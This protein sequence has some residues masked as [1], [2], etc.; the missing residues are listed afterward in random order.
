MISLV[1]TQQLHLRLDRIVDGKC[2][3]ISGKGNDGVLHGTAQVIPD[4][5]LGASLS[6]NGST[7]SLDL[8]P[9]CIPVGNELTV[10]FWAYGGST[11][12]RNSAVIEATGAG[13]QI[14]LSIR[15]PWGDGTVSFRCGN[16]GAAADSIA[17]AAQAS[18][19]QGAWTHW[20]FTKSATNGQMMIYRNGVL[21]QT[22]TG[23]T[24]AIAASSTVK[25][26]VT[27]DGVNYYPGKLAQ[28][29][30]YS[31][32][33]S[34][35]AI[36]HDMEADQTALS[37][38]RKSY[39]I[40]FRLYNDDEQDV[41]DITDDPAGQNLHL[42]VSNASG[43]VINLVAPASTEA[44]AS[45]YH[46][47]L[48]FRPDVLSVAAQTYTSY[49]AFALQP[50]QVQTNFSQ[51]FQLFTT[52]STVT[53]TPAATSFTVSQSTTTPTPQ[54]TQQPDINSTNT[55]QA[56]AVDT[57]STLQGTLQQQ[58]WSL[59][60]HQEPDASVTIYFLST[61]AR[62]LPPGAQVA[63]TFPHVSASG[64]GGARGTRVELLYQQLTFGSDASPITG[65][66]QIYLSIVNQRGQKAIP[67]HVNFVGFNTILN[68]GNTQNTL[69][70]RITNVLR[71][72]VIA[73]NPAGSTTPSRFILSFDVQ[74]SGEVRDWALGTTSQVNAIQITP[75]DVGN[76]T[77]TTEVEGNSP[78]WIVTPQSAKT[79]L[80]ADEALQLTI[81]N[82]ISSLPSSQSS[83]YVRY[84]NIPG[85][86]D[87]QFVVTIEKS[88]LLYR[89][90]NVG[91]GALNPNTTLTISAAG[92]PPA[93]QLVSHL[94]LRRE[95]T[96]QSGD[97]ILFLELYQDDHV[98]GALTVP[99]VHPSIRFHHS[100]R[101]WQRI[102][103]R[104]DGIHFKTGDLTSDGYTGVIAGNGYFGGNAG[105]AP[106][107]LHAPLEVKGT[108]Y[109]FAITNAQEHN[110]G[111]VNWS[112]DKLYFQYREAGVFKGDALSLD[113]NGTITIGAN[114][115]QQGVNW[116]GVSAVQYQSFPSGSHTIGALA[117]S[118]ALR[119]VG[120]DGGV[121]AV[122]AGD[123][124]A[125]A[126]YGIVVK[127]DIWARN[128]YFHIDHPT[129]PEYHLIHACLE[130]SESGVYY[131]GRAQLADGRARIRLPDYF[132]ALTRS[133]GRTILLTPEGREPFL[134]S[135]DPIKDGTFMVYG[136]APEGVFSW[137]VKAVRADVE[138]LETEVK[139]Q[140]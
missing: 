22:G 101:F 102:E 133:D 6:L 33:L 35:D 16:D 57:A 124:M 103:G 120:G 89:D 104:N 34:V 115:I 13:G 52:Q 73:L 85:Y 114:S 5:I 138:P 130:G 127:G 38:F 26:G 135:Y 100:N 106:S 76:W 41:L 64:A 17:K 131:R 10:S 93:T 44:S 109:Q 136:T 84:E 3:D 129:R 99:E 118:N 110:W 54:S 97:K 28:V 75:S 27:A 51:S 111:L 40:D 21:W 132:E 61:Q 45:N 140:R 107:S 94:Q 48:K 87:G 56:F 29:R 53:T 81:S 63:M 15:L 42:E 134:L 65:R 88:P 20:T 77:V 112:D 78:E 46:F 139:R 72:S 117:S 49:A 82:I 105:I 121:L 43:Q 96:Q 59:G 14:T 92:G 137:E 90:R 8:P 50:S 12:P 69:T 126:S 86:W 4:D 128:K 19:F 98:A 116:T 47:A 23:A 113:K 123:V 58:G 70:L 7:T 62:T 95:A 125:W 2:V 36:I 30:I 25:L 67:L 80:A 1:G 74:A 122:N 83:L 11:L 119:I 39:P 9:G 66:R 60:Y 24:R 18:D 91:I 31:Q 108:D 37:S 68:D 55:I 79:M 32:V 71:D